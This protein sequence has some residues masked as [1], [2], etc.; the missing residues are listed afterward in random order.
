[1]ER[2]A[3]LGIALDEAQLAAFR[4]FHDTLLA[5]NQRLNLTALSTTEAVQ[6][7]H[8][9]DSLSGLPLLPDRPN[10]RVIDVGAGAGFPGIPL[11]I[12]RPDLHLTLL[13]ATRKK[14]DFLRRLV[15]ELSLSGVT[16]V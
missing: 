8:F 2:V 15:E 1:L 4:Q 9:L 5:E 11:K 6:S 3:A 7:K 14:T 10:L 12:V 16:V 13:E